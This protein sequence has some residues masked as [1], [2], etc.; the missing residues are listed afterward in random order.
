M[1]R[2]EALKVIPPDRLKSIETL[3]EHNESGVAIE[4]LCDNLADFDVAI[5]PEWASAIEQLIKDMALDSS[6]G[7]IIQDHSRP[8]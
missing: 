5:R 1:L 2:A 4:I 7:E 3:F 8:N 6:Y